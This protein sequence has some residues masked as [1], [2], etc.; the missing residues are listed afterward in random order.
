MLR[1][2]CKSKIHK[3]IVTQTNLKYKGSI[4]IDAKLIEAADILPGEI[5]LVVNINTG[6]RFETYVIKG[7]PNSGV[8][9]LNGGA[10]RLGELGDELIVISYGFFNEQEI[11][12]LKPK[13]IVVNN[14][15]KI[16]RK[17]SL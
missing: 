6:I 8:I 10:A 17:C 3:P 14:K 13:L 1:M 2:M 4:T 11:K 16:V 5:V 15:N 7:K 9:G 12:N